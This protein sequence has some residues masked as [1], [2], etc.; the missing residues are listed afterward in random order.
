MLL[1]LKEVA[2]RL[3]VDYSTARELVLTGKL[4][5]IRLGGRRRIQ[6][7]EEDLERFIASSEIVGPFAGPIALAEPRKTALI[8]RGQKLP[9]SRPHQWRRAFHGK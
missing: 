4:Q 2:E 9:D 5:G 3:R 8:Q 7:R 6:V 1:F